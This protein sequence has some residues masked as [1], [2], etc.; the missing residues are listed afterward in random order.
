[1]AGVVSRNEALGGERDY[2][3]GRK[4]MTAE[5]NAACGAA[6]EA[7]IEQIVI[8]DSH[9]GGNNLLIDE[10]PDCVEVVRSWPRE[11]MMMQ[12]VE[13]GPFVGAALK[14]SCFPTFRASKESV[15][16]GLASRLI[17]CWQRRN[18]SVS[19]PI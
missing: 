11:L 15:R 8:A 6:L 14:Q 13:Q 9:G 16:T 1:V 17:T 4:W 12:G 7:G 19:L 3:M 2:A 5:V 18:A 10:L